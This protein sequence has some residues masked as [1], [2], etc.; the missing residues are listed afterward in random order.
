MH[1]ENLRGLSLFAGAGIGEAYL[2]Q[3]DV[4][5]IVANELATR[6]AELHRSTYPNCNMICGDIKDEKVF[7][8]IIID[9]FPNLPQ[10]LTM[11]FLSKPAN[12]KKR[13]ICLKCSGNRSNDTGTIG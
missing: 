12:G 7:K 5:I 1:G 3:A 6:R 13:T 4:D 2:S 10:G 8:K 11:S 9:P